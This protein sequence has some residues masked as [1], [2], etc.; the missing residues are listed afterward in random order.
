MER[1]DTAYKNVVETRFDIQATDYLYPVKVDR[2]RKTLSAYNYGTAFIRKQFKVNPVTIVEQTMG[3]VP[4][5]VTIPYLYAGRSCW[6]RQTGLYGAVGLGLGG[7]GAFITTNAGNKVSNAQLEALAT[8]KAFAKMNSTAFDGGVFL[9]ELAGTISM[10][11]NPMQG[12]VNLLRRKKW[13][14]PK[15]VMSAGS[16]T[17]MEFRYGM[18][19]MISDIANIQKLFDKQ[20]NRVS[21]VYHPARAGERESL[22]WTSDG[23]TALGSFVH[24]WHNYG[25]REISYHVGLTYRKKFNFPAFMHE[26]G[27][28]IQDLPNVLWELT[29]L[30]FVADWYFSCGDW[31][32]AITPNPAVNYIGGFLSRKVDETL[33]HRITKSMYGAYTGESGAFA[34]GRLQY[35]NRTA[36]PGLPALPVRKVSLLGLER[37]ID[38]VILTMQR[39]PTAWKRVLFR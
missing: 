31:L 16:D 18:R 29:P 17:W 1:F 25:R 23:S 7:G 28:A 5:E 11:R 39:I 22:T 27:M 36:A 6:R 38:S 10:L 4:S 33:V 8:V 19:P 2:K 20:A 26:H 34:T 30:S 9:G 37:S 13:K 15:A 32:R 12:I 14:N 24:Y 35:L 3:V 21:R